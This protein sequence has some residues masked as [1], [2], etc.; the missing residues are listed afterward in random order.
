MVASPR[1]PWA[2]FAAVAIALFFALYPLYVIRPFRHQG[3]RELAAALVVGRWA[4][5]VTLLCAAAAVFHLWRWWRAP[6]TGSSPRAGL[7]GAAGLAIAAAVFA[8]WNIS[9]LMFHSNL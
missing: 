5:G 4:P 1:R 3:A 7:L 9:E 6:G 2:F 8:R